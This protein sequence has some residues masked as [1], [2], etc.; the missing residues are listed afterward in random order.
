MFFS[1]APFFS[2]ITQ[3][4][5]ATYTGPAD[6]LPNTNESATPFDFDSSPRYF[7][8]FSF[9]IHVSKSAVSTK[10][11]GMIMSISLI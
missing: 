1:E 3:N 11:T 10:I 4:G 9:G 5:N 2:S 7:V 8:I 6:M